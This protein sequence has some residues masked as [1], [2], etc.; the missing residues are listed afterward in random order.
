M[1]LS[2]G[3]IPAQNHNGMRNKIKS[4]GRGLL[5]KSKL[6]VT[7]A[8]YIW[9]RHLNKSQNHIEIQRIERP[10]ITFQSVAILDELGN[11]WDN[12][13]EIKRKLLNEIIKSGV[14]KVTKTPTGVVNQ[15]E[16]RAVIEVLKPKE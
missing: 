13:R 8:L 1:I 10:I 15:Y 9:L 6:K 7:Y 16:Y 2:S 14:I 5:A 4:W 11:E 3:N 12:S